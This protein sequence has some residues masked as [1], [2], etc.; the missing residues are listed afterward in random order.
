MKFYSVKQQQCKRDKIQV[1]IFLRFNT[2]S[3][4]VYIYLPLPIGLLPP[5]EVSTGRLEPGNGLNKDVS[6]SSKLPLQRERA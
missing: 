3:S 4:T 2:P 6:E 1:V 5:W